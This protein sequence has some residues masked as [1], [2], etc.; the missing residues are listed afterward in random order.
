MFS[1]YRNRAL[2]VFF[3][4]RNLR[5]LPRDSTSLPVSRQKCKFKLPEV[6]VAGDPGILFFY[7]LLVGE[8]TTNGKE[9]T[10]LIPSV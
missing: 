8:R 2:A 9:A 5:T 4:Q 10:E 7:W 6:M 1:E 3:V